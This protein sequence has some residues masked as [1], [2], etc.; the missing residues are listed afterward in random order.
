MIKSIVT[1]NS[2]QGRYDA[3]FNA[4]YQIMDF[5]FLHVCVKGGKYFCV[6]DPSSPYNTGGIIEKPGQMIKSSVLKRSLFER[7]DVGFDAVYHI[8]DFPSLHVCVKGERYQCIFDPNVQ[9][10]IGS[11]IVKLRQMIKLSVIKKLYDLEGIMLAL[12]QSTTL[13]LSPI[14]VCINR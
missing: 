10:N 7:Y 5:P 12:M 1:K 8:T 3:V 6:F 11:S 4:V 9:Y 13:Q 14:P 2:L